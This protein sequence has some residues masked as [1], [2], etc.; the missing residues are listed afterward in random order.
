MSNWNASRP[1]EKLRAAL[2]EVETLNNPLQAENVYLQEEIRTE[3]KF[4]EMVGQGLVLVAVSRKVERI[5]DTDATVLVTGE[6]GTGKELIA[7]ALHSRSGRKHRPL[8]KVNCGAVPAQSDSKAELFGH[9]KGVFTLGRHRP[10]RGT[11]RA[12]GRRR[13]AVSRR[14][15]PGS[16]LDTQVK[17]LRV[18]QEQESSR[19]AA[20][21]RFQSTS[22]SLRLP[23]AI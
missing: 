12:G 22:G 2:A 9:V 21:R 16:T 3:H 17:L 5:A 4:D 18:L 8:V 11:V 6:T 15:Q 13:D 20:A 14:S 10:S 1:K 19:L 23:T 7:R